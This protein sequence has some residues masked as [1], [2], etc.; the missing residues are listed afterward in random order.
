VTYF[1]KSDQPMLRFQV[2]TFDGTD[3]GREVAPARTFGFLDEVGPLL[4]AGLAKGASLANSVVFG[5]RHLLNNGLRFE[6]E[7][8]R[9]KILDFLGDLAPLS[10]RLTGWF[11]CVRSGHRTNAEFVRYLHEGIRSGRGLSRDLSPASPG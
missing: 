7:P 10:A 1:F 4:S 6:D 2:A 9:H 3:Y 11:F 5:R 8:S